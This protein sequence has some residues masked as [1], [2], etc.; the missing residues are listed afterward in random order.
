MSNSLCIVSAFL[1]IGREQWTCFQRSFPQ[2]LSNFLPYTKMTHEMIVFMDDRHSNLLKELCKGADHIRII[3]INREFMQ[4]HIH[5]YRQLARERE[6]MESAKFKQLVSHRLSHPECCKPE[7]NIMQHAKIDFL[8]YVIKN[9]LSPAEYYAW[10]DFGYFQRSDRIPSKPLDL[11]KFDLNRINFQAMSPLSIQDSDIIYTLRN[12]PE[13]VGGFFYLGEA[14]LL[15]QYQE[16]YHKICQQFH[17]M[18]IVDD[19]QHIMI[20]SVYRN[21]DLFCIWN[22]RGWHLTYLF[23][24]QS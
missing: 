18:G 12:A 7:Y 4:E 20:Q 21:P 14:R 23:F 1:D 24:Q 22:L 3:P 17:D 16:L 9:K 11:M 6:I 10:S 2:Y 15:L 13:R 5:A 19:D 8:A